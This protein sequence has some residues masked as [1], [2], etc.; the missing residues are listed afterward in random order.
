MTT[1][2]KCRAED[3]GE[4]SLG[5]RTEPFSRRWQ[6]IMSWISELLC[7]MSAVNISFFFSVF[8]MDMTEAV[9]CDFCIIVKRVFEG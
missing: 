4:Q 2:T 3:H 6:H 9:I 8:G 5:S 1:R 7:P